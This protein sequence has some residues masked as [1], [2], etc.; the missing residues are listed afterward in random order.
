MSKLARDRAKQK[1]GSA[2]AAYLTYREIR[3]EYAR[4]LLEEKPQFDKIQAEWLARL[5][6]FVSDYPKAEDTP[7]ALL[8]L[9][10]MSEMDDKKTTEAKKWYEQLLKNFPEHGLAAKVNG[11]I[12]R[13]DSEGKVLELSGPVLGGAGMFT[14]SQLRN[15]VVVVYYWAS[16]NQQCTSDFAKLKLLLST[17]G[18]KGVELVCV[19]LDNKAEEATAFLRSNPALGIQLFREGGLDSPLAVQYGVMALPNLFL[20]G[21]DGKVVS[22]TVQVNG[23]ED[24]VKKLVDAK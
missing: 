1:P 16:W 7:D 18:S 9:G 4:K 10:M 13:L 22:R 11:A 12:R 17:Y 24:E 21:K 3:S 19:N 2:L 5:S 6:K 23:L 8:Q 20:V 15:K 14:I